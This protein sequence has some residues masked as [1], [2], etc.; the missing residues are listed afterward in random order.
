MCIYKYRLKKSKLK[1][2]RKRK[3]ENTI[4]FYFICPLKTKYYT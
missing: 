4:L 2:K 3:K 1:K